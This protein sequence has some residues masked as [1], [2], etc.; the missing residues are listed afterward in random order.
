MNSAGNDQ[1]STFII[2]KLRL[3]L[4]HVQPREKDG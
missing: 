1:K 4:L 3:M 2:L